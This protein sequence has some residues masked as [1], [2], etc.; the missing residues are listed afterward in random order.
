MTPNATHHYLS[1]VKDELGSRLLPALEAG[2][3]QQVAM[4]G[5]YILSQLLTE[6]RHRPNL[7]ATA[8]AELTQCLPELRAVLTDETDLALLA[9]LD[10]QL[11]NPQDTHA[12]EPALQTL[13]QRLQAHPDDT[14]AMVLNKA[15]VGIEHRLHGNFIRLYL[16]EIAR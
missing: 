13:S 2:Q 7:L 9:Q 11:G 14:R 6:A 5:Q 8:Q 10:A 3:M 1:I 12:L 15:L 4:C 16:E